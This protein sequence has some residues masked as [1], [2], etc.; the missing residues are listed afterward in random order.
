MGRDSAFGKRLAEMRAQRGLSL[1]ALGELASFSRGFIWDLEAG[2]KSPGAATAARLDEALGAG[3][4]L[5]AL[6]PRGTSAPRATA[7]VPTRQLETLRREVTET[8]SYRAWA[9]RS[10]PRWRRGRWAR[11]TG[12]RTRAKPSAPRR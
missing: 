8:I 2:N 1:R 11:C 10:P 12:A 7:A 4:R 9:E 5:A 6:A 3:G